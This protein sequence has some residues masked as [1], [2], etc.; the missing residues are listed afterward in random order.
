MNIIVSREDAIFIR[1]LQ[2]I[3]CDDRTVAI[4]VDRRNP[5]RKRAL[6]EGVQDRRRADR[7]P[8]KK[9]SIWA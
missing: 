3:F 6:P 5:K 7:P 2:R 8:L 9:K 4:I 1:K